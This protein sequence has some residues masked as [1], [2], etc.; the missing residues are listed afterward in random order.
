VT[1][2]AVAYGLGVTDNGLG[3]VPDGTPA[4]LGHTNDEAFPE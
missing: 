1:G 4:V 2:R 3:V